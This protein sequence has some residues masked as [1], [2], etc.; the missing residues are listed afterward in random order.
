MLC[1][2]FKPPLTSFSIIAESSTIVLFQAAEISQ[3]FS[4]FPFIL[5]DAGPDLQPE[6]LII[7]LCAVAVNE[8]PQIDFSRA[9]YIKAQNIFE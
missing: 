8:L 7:Y 1:G 6:A 2:E 4:T 3:K 9:V 5:R